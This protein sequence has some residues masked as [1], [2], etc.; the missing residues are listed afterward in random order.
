LHLSFFLSAMG[1]EHD[2]FSVTGQWKDSSDEMQEIVSRMPGRLAMY[3][4]SAVLLVFLAGIGFTWFVKFPDIVKGSIVITSNPP[5]ITLNA[6]IEGKIM[7]LKAEEEA[8]KKGELIAF[9]LTNAEVNDVLLL[10]SLLKRDT[11]NNYQLS[12][13]DKDLKLGSIQNLFGQFINAREDISNFNNNDLERKQIAHLEQQIVTYNDLNKNLSGQAMTMTQELKLAKE[14]FAMDSILFGQRVIAPLEFNL[15][16]AGYYEQQRAHA[17]LHG[18]LLANQLQIQSLEK[19]I[20]EVSAGR[21]ERMNLLNVNY[22]NRKKELEAMIAEWKE[23]SLFISPVDGNLARLAFLETFDFVRS[24]TP[25]FSVIPHKIGMY[26]KMELELSGSGKVKEGQHV[27]IR[28][29]NYPAEQYGKVHAVVESISLLPN[30]NKYSVRLKLPNGLVSSYRQVL[31]FREQLQGDAEI[32]T[33]DIRL[34]DRLF[35]EFRSLTNFG[36][37]GE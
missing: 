2:E 9:F 4:S 18:T 29:H 16:Q 13:G 28:L 12:V 37:T 31:P 27:I 6:R 14:R 33:K 10:E 20:I 34:M 25:L 26:G 5:P 21:S 35:F 7:L 3:G 36:S 11:L 8:V 17:N 23:T 19:Q 32:I 1:V 15:A 24:G 30:E 22:N